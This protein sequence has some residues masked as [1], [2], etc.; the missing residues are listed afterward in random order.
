MR[1]CL[2]A[3]VF[4]LVGVLYNKGLALMETGKVFISINITSLLMCIRIVDNLTFDCRW[5]SDRH[6]GNGDECHTGLN[7]YVAGSVLLISCQMALLALSV[8]FIEKER[9]LAYSRDETVGLRSFED[10][11]G[12]S[13]I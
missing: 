9:F 7:L 6:H 8:L 10:T 13:S 11:V 2:S 12:D 4:V 5:W 3:A 1:V